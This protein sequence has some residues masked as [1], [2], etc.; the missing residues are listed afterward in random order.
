MTSQLRKYITLIA[1]FIVSHTFASFGQNDFGKIISF[2]KVV[3]NF[4]DIL[5]SSGEQHCTF[6]YKNIGDKPLVIHRVI[7]SCGCTEPTWDKK[8][9][10]PG[11]KGEIKVTFKNDQG[12]YPF[13]KGITVYVSDL[14]KPVVLRIRGIAHN[15]KKTLQEMFPEGFG[16]FGMKS[17]TLS[18]GQ[19]E[20]ALTRN[21]SVQVANLSNK[22]IKVTFAEV[23]PGLELTLSS[24]TIAPKG[25]STLTFSVDTKKAKG[26]NGERAWGKTIFRAKVLVNGVPQ[27]GYLEVETLIK[28]NFSNLSEAQIK[29]G[30]LPKMVSSSLSIGKC[31]IGE[32]KKLKFSFINMGKETLKIYKIDSSEGGC[33]FN[34]PKETPPSGKGEIE[35]T[36]DTSK[37]KKGEL[38]NIVSVITNA[39]VRPIVNIFIIGDME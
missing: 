15:K 32:V 14:S 22:Q 3:H 7:T 4:G 34:F 25:N 13:D 20:Q 26:E 16:P 39:P 37:Y 17:T 8:P 33:T 24:N 21:E 6:T 18:L 1:I 10:L 36:V 23:T 9:I 38:L 28:E 11:E 35:V 30:A 29:A 12:P 2:D 19:I 27:K 31:P 5:I